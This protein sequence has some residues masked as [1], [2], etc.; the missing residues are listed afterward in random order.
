MIRVG[1][2]G[3]G[4]IHS[5]HCDALSQ[6]EGAQLT[7]VC[8]VV[9]ERVQ[10]AAEKYGV[11]ACHSL[12]ELWSHVDMV[13]VCVPS[14]LHAQ[15]GVAAAAQ[16]KH[17]LVEKPIDIT[18]D[19]A[20]SLVA[21]CK[22][23]GVKL[24][25]IS[26]H[27]FAHDIRRLREAVQSGALGRIL[28]GDC[29][30]KWYRSQAY[31][32]SGDW[33][34]TWALDGGGC[35]MNQGVHYVDML[36]WVMGGIAAVQAQTRTTAHERIEVEDIANVLVEFKNGAT[37]IIQAGTSYYP[38]MAERLEIHGLYGTIVIE[39]DKAVVWKIDPEGSQLGKYGDGKDKLPA[40]SAQLSALTEAA[41]QK[42]ASASGDPTA[43]WTAQHRMQIEDFIRSIEEDRDP[44][45]TGE[46]ALEP[47][48]IILAIYQSGRE[49]GT[50][51]EIA[52]TL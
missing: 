17:V 28:E 33:R 34:G 51:V 21:A 11:I 27:R 49:G 19:N 20:K 14:G 24:G 15:I 38:G 47:L 43:I 37:G 52:S 41:D 23:A 3:C 42:E 16:G 32:D 18:L 40:A 9:P 12:E 36:Q 48:K 1:V 39:G 5:T 26:Q 25:T 30:N 4:V 13:T 31:Y 44:E 46:A 22:A 45:V 7:A 50:R 29:Y 10:A 6:I 2:V 8:D 35:L